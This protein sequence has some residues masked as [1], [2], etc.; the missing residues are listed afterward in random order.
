MKTMEL[1]EYLKQFAPE[2]NVV[3][4]PVDTD[5]RI[6]YHYDLLPVKNGVDQN[7]F[8]VVGLLEAVPLDELE[9]EGSGNE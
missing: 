7:P 1:I 5:K 4:M 2:N 9:K 3:I 6:A 8:L